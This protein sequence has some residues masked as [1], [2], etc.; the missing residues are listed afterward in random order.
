MPL[1]QYRGAEHRK[2]LQW[3]RS[4]SLCLLQVQPVDLSS[5]G[6]AHMYT[7]HGG[8]QGYVDLVSRQ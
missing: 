3:A 6:W 2:A 1:Q 8:W 7:K 4:A 5:C